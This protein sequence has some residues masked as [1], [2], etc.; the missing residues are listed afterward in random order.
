MS[1]IEEKNENINYENFSRMC[2]HEGWTPLFEW[3][4]DHKPVG[5]IEYKNSSLVLIGVCK[6]MFYFTF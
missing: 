5:V 6:K 4:E 1:T 3:C 2:L